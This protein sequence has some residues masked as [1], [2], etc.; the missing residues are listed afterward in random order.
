MLVILTPSAAPPT[1][2]IC[3]ISNIRA[4][5]YTT[6]VTPEASTVNKYRKLSASPPL[7][8]F[9]TSQHAKL[10]KVTWIT[11]IKP[12]VDCSQYIQF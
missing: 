2:S 5:P 12:P 10:I 4:H 9:K 3:F 7:R 6:N 11:Y 1:S 8:L